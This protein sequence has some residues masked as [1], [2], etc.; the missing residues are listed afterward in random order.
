MELGGGGGST[1]RE[2]GEERW[3]GCFRRGDLERGKHL[4]Y[5]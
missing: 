1:L 3:D 4:K 5:K 2:A